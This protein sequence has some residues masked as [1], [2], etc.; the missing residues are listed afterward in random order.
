[1][2]TSVTGKPMNR[3]YLGNRHTTEV[4]DLQR[5]TVQCQIREIITARHAVVFTPDT[6][7]QAKAEGYDNCAY[8]LGGSTR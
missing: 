2:A 8:C 3:R 4:H 5:E 7:A 6:L 1:M